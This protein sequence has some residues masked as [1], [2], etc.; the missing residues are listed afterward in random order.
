MNRDQYVPFNNGSS[1]YTRTVPSPMLVAQRGLDQPP[2]GNSPQLEA[3]SNLSGSSSG[4]PHDR[5][6]RL[7]RFRYRP[8]LQAEIP[9]TLHERTGAPSSCIPPVPA[10]RKQSLHESMKPRSFHQRGLQ[11]TPSFYDEECQEDNVSLAGNYQHQHYNPPLKSDRSSHSVMSFSTHSTHYKLPAWNRPL[12]EVLPGVRLPLRGSEE[13]WQAFCN[14]QVEGNHCPACGTFF[15]C[16]IAATLA[17]CPFCRSVCPTDAFGIAPSL[18]LG[19]SLAGAKE[20]M[21]LRASR[22]TYGR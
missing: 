20:E 1:Q 18:G 22:H 17:L 2:L 14:D 9:T 13:T 7:G 6:G 4:E 12:V 15:Y 11:R 3:W 5:T 19:L 8:S 21:E 16:H 10:Q